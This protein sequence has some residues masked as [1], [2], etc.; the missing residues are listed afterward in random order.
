LKAGNCAEKCAAACHYVTQSKW[1]SYESRKFLKNYVNE[2]KIV[3]SFFWGRGAKKRGGENEGNL[4]YVIENKWRQ[5]A[6]FP[7]FHYVNENTRVKPIS[8]LC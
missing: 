8:P 3:I 2:T 6:R 1:V 5:N 7:P 4:H